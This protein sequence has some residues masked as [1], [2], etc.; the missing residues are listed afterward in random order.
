MPP[1]GTESAPTQANKICDL[2]GSGFKCL[3][4]LR[5]FDLRPVG[6]FANKSEKQTQ[7]S[8]QNGKATNMDAHQESEN[9]LQVL[10][11]FWRRKFIIIFTTLIGLGCGYWYYLE[12]T[13]QYLSTA[14]LLIS[15]R[16]TAPVVSDQVAYTYV[17]KLQTQIQILM[18]ASVLKKAAED[19]EL[20]KLG[21]NDTAT[22]LAQ[23]LTVTD[24]KSTE[25]IQLG[26]T[27]SDSQHA[28]VALKAIVAAY[29]D[30]LRESY[31]DVG[32]ETAT[33]IRSASENLE[34]KILRKRA[35]YAEFRKT[36]SGELL[37]MDGALAN[38]HGKRLTELLSLRNS[39]DAKKVNLDAELEI[40]RAAIGAGTLDKS[41]ALYVIGKLNLLSDGA[42][43]GENKEGRVESAQ[44]ALELQKLTDLFLL[45]RS[46][47]AKYG[48][49]HPLVTE[50]KEKI[51]FLTEMNSKIA[52]EQKQASENNDQNQ[53]R[54]PTLIE[55]PKNAEE[56]AEIYA[57]VLDR[58]LSRVTKEIQVADEEIKK[59]KDLSQSFEAI[60]VEDENFR[61]AIKQYESL[62]DQILA[63]LDEIDIVKQSG[64]T[65]AIELNPPSAP[66]Q[67]EPQLA[68]ILLLAGVIAAVMG[69]GLGYLLDGGEGAFR[70]PSDIV[71]SLDL[72]I[73]GQ[74]PSIEA[75]R[76]KRAAGLPKVPQTIITAH[77]PSSSVAEAFRAIR[78]SLYFSGEGSGNQVIQIT[79]PTPGDGKSTLCA[80]L[81][82][83]IAKSGKKVLLIDADFRRPT[84][85]RIFGINNEVGLTSSLTHVGA[86]QPRPIAT[87]IQHLDILPSGPSVGN[88]SELLSG[89]K[90]GEV[91]ETLRKSYDF[92]L[93]DSP[94]VLAVTDPLAIAVQTDGVILAL[95][96]SR[97]IQFAS[98]RAKESL[99]RVG[100]NILGV[101][102]N[103]FGRGSS[104]AK[105]VARDYGYGYSRYGYESRASA[106]SLDDSVNSQQNQS[107]LESRNREIVDLPAR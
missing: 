102:V 78:T 24:L 89:T 56:C 66:A 37:V 65:R 84:L 26:F 43:F 71:R 80:N 91:I 44:T 76:V 64:G 23:R 38:V 70:R 96:L 82:V 2:P 55:T 29:Q 95:R 11:V 20:K 50:V 85:H 41:T 17:N 68:R 74:V 4:D 54:P 73:L 83:S 46:L 100:A 59:L 31:R 33:L 3:L 69:F 8:V 21:R 28:P 13:P 107:E 61:E 18:S 1:R 16:I 5:N 15:E 106:D 36:H 57:G 62:S 94:P 63:R 47:G 52:E 14:T 12:A 40:L 19:K 93:I 32:E 81:A 51:R 35:D 7:M 39:L 9:R 77:Q 60:I 22:S 99:D 90:W 34:Q 86:K 72:Q 105:G 58:D 48:D 88:P 6:R 101:V 42:L 98:K 103:G 75:R 30:V 45:E 87:E 92:I 104:F 10:E 49:D 27:S 25:T 79:S 97:G 67:I 53:A